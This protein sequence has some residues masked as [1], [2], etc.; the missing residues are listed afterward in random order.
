LIL[1]KKK[2]DFFA[3]PPPTPPAPAG[4]SHFSVR[5]AQRVDLRNAIALLARSQRNSLLITA[6]NRIIFSTTA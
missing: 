4:G 6:L 5:T 1:N 2:L 3:L